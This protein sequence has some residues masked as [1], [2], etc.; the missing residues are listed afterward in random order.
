MKSFLFMLL[1]GLS[2]VLQLNDLCA[3]QTR[4]LALAGSTRQA[5]V[6]K[7]LICEAAD[8][9]R[10]M[11]AQV[12]L[13]DLKDYPMP[14]YDADLESE[15]G[16]PEKAKQLRQLMI[17]SDAI[18]IASPNYNGS[19]PGVLKNALDWA[20]RTE[21]AR[22]SRE[23]FRGKKFGLMSASP[24]RSGGSKGLNHL[25]EIIEDIGGCVI[26]QQV[27]IPFAH[28]AFDSNGCLK[29]AQQKLALTELIRA[30]MK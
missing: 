10:Q 21:K 22:P 11:G 18:L 12:I 14:L 9:A 27:S 23:A 24:G 4:I 2:L 30:V 28:K 16:M 7:K 29:N 6:N 8:L 20:S 15:Q 19:L 17:E 13:I 1:L 5:S 26:A 3:A 25:K